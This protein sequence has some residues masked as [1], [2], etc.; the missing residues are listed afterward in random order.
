MGT[1][2]QSVFFFVV[3]GTLTGCLCL[4]RFLFIHDTGEPNYPERYTVCS[5][6]F[7]FPLENRRSR[8]GRFESRSRAS[9]YVIK[10]VCR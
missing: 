9:F 2:I 4:R 8:T 3:K 10:V 1:L 6:K 7:F 5:S